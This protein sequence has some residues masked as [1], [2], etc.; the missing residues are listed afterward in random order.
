MI[1]NP[2]ALISVVMPVHNAGKYLK[3]AVASILNQQN[4]LLELIL[5]DDHSIDKA[6]ES[7]PDNLIQDSRVKVFSSACRGVV[8]AMKTGFENTNGLYIARMDADDI[9]KPNRLSEQYQYLQQHPEIGIA[10]AQVKIFSESD[11]EQGFLLY[12]KWLNQLC[13]P[14]DIAREIFIESPIP[15]PTAFFRREV[16]E[17]LNGYQDS[18]WAEDYDIWLRAHNLGIKMGKPKGILLDWREHQKRL[19]HCDDRYNNKLFIKAKAYYL[20]RSFHLKQRKAVIWGAGPTGKFIHDILVQQNIE[21]SAFIE[22]NP[23]RIAGTTRGLPV[24]HFSE[25]NQYTCD[26][27]TDLIIGAVGARGARDKIR[28]ALLDI[29]K[30]EGTDFLFAA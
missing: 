12:E 6:I 15:N 11:I 7:L 1:C 28:Q 9:S 14:K 5:V 2:N 13:N 24:L 16:Y 21:V 3:E 25:V 4:V 19:T 23:A 22:V 17:K 18:E 20:S 29:G 27:S 30:E 26:N 10:G 8:S